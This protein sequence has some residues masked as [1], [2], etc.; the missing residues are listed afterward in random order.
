MQCLANGQVPLNFSS[1][2]TVY[3]SVSNA[4]ELQYI[5]VSRYS[6]FIFLDHW[7]MFGLKIQKVS[8]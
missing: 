3:Y 4:F 7:I 5:S 6:R 1:L 2:Y 8:D